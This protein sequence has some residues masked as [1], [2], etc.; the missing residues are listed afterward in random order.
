M[1]VTDDLTIRAAEM[2]AFGEG[3]GP[4]REGLM[5]LDFIAV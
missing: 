4:R 3:E 2:G 5:K 1:S